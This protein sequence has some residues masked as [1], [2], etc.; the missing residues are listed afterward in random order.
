MQK[1]TINQQ[2]KI[3]F[4]SLIMLCNPTTKIDIKIYNH[5]NFSCFYNLGQKSLTLKL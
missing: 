1:I 3:T 2:D 5:L 4:P